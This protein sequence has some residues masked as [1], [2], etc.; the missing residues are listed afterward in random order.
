MNKKILIVRGDSD[1]AKALSFV[2]SGT[3]YQTSCHTSA[4]KAVEAAR[5]ERFDLAIT[6]G[7]IPENQQ[8]LA[9]V[10]R[11][12]ETQP[13]LPIFL[14]SNEPDLDAVINGIRAG[15]TDIIENADDLKNIFES[16]HN[17]L[18]AHDEADSDVSWEDIQ[19]VEKVLSA[20]RPD[21]EESEQRA[22]VSD[23]EDFIDLQARFDEV[24]QELESK[25]S[26]Y[27]SLQSQLAKAESL[28]DELRNQS[29]GDG[30][31]TLERA[32]DLDEKERELEERASKISKQKVS[33]EIQL[34][35]L[36][37]QRIEFE[38]MRS[39]VSSNPPTSGEAQEQLDLAQ[40]KANEA[41]LDY[42]AQIQDLR[43][44]LEQIK[45]SSGSSE[46]LESENRQLREELHGA[47]E[48][49]AEKEFLL[50]QKENELSSLQSSA[51]NASIEELEEEKRLLEIEKFK[52]QEKLDR[53]ELEKRSL[54]EDHG[55]KA[56]EIQ[57][58]KR[59]AEISL[60]EMQHRIKEEQL[61]LQA[62]QGQLKDEM[63]QFEQAKQNFQEDV[64]ELQRKQTELSQVEARLRKLEEEAQNGNAL[65]SSAPSDIPSVGSA[66][67]TPKSEEAKNPNDNAKDPKSWSKPPMGGGGRGPLRIGRKS[68]I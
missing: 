33:V 55:K 19:A 56:R 68:S 60:R 13:S 7:R 43:K 18:G 34:A 37:A 25:S 5:H 40:Q 12:K 46:K 6:D 17:F 38:E 8:E 50:S 2:L 9:L 30:T 62:Q 61:K 31:Q 24:Q 45:S 32:A 51:S 49:V 58:E 4:D 35:E 57:V 28:L 41:R 10:S 65:P 3:G 52:M 54:D 27:D 21:T 66:P 63:R 1:E 14:L 26:E 36:D 48:D 15:V 53:L 23:S 64:Q 11:L 20:L 47:R 42:E 29:G 59:D 67:F 22:D 16:T 44:E 39:S